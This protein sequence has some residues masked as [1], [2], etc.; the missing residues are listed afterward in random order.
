[1]G[2]IKAIAIELLISLLLE[3]IRN[4]RITFDPPSLYTRLLWLGILIDAAGVHLEVI[5]WQP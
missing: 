2:F 1:M 3:V 4:T 5:E